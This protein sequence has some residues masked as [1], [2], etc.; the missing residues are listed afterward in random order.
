MFNLE[1]EMIC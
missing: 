1:N